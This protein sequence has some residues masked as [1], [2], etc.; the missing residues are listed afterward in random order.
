MFFFPSENLSITPKMQ[1][2]VAKFQL[3]AKSMHPYNALIPL[4]TS[5]Y[6]LYF[7]YLHP[8]MSGLG[9]TDWCRTVQ[10]VTS[11]LALHSWQCSCLCSHF[12]AH[13]LSLKWKGH[14]L[15]AVGVKQWNIFWVNYWISLNTIQ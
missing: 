1:C 2:S 3:Q 13:H 12:F 10:T 9:S 15:P 4:P 11:G 7:R 5:H 8:A 14:C 6:S